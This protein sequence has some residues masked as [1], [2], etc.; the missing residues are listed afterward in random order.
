MTGLWVSRTLWT[1]SLFRFV[2][3]DSASML[4]MLNLCCVVQAVFVRL[5]IIIVRHRAY[6]GRVAN[7]AQIRGTFSIA[8]VCCLGAGSRWSGARG[9]LLWP[10]ATSWRAITGC[11]Y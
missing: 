4:T 1:S 5:L 2:A 9:A 7:L 3:I 11:V 6:L 10:M 8:A